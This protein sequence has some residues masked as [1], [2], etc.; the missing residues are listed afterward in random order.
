MGLSIKDVVMLVLTMVIIGYIFPLAIGTVSAMDL[1]VIELNG[2]AYAITELVDPAV[3]T[4]ITVVLPIVATI[5][6]ILSFLSY[7]R[8]D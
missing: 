5:G 1:A 4:L 8:A 2:T 3:I 6:I 7:S